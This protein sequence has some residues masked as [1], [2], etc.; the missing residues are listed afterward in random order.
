MRYVGRSVATLRMSVASEV[1]VARNWYK[2]WR[3]QGLTEH[4]IEELNHDTSSFSWEVFELA[5]HAP[6]G[7]SPSEWADRITRACMLD[8]A[9]RA[10]R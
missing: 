10:S 6:D 7:L 1:N 8:A 2:H 4:Q 5:A 3:E 9:E